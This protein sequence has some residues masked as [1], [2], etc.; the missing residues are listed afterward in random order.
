MSLSRKRGEAVDWFFYTMV[1]RVLPASQQMILSPQL[2]AVEIIT[3]WLFRPP[4]Q[5][6][7]FTR[8]PSSL[9]QSDIGMSF[10]VRSLRLLKRQRMVWLGLLL[11]WELRTNFPYHKSWWM[12]AIRRIT[13]RNSDSDLILTW[14]FHLSSSEA[15]Q[16]LRGSCKKFYHW[17]RIISVL[18]FI[19]HILITNLQSIPP[20]LKHIL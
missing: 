15:Y 12:N 2:G 18:H 4:L 10:Q 1:Q 9:K 19:K 13:S 16:I 7:I 5:E 14:R 11:W 20:L 8:A 3:L 17:V 6:L